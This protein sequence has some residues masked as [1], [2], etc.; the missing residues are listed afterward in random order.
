MRKFRWFFFVAMILVLAACANNNEEEAS[1]HGSVNDGEVANGYGAIDHGVDDKQTVDDA[2]EVEIGFGL[3]GD[4]IEEAS[5]VP[6]EEKE[7]ILEVFNVY[8]DAFNKKEIDRYMDTLSDQTESFDKAEERAYMEDVFAQFDPSREASD[9]T[10]VKYSDAEAQVFAQLKTSMKQLSSGLE[11]NQS[12][13]QVTVLKKED[14][15][16]KV[17]SIH[18]IGDTQNTD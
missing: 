8:I 16:W 15:E 18:Y 10:I 3:T 7:R 13:R 14:G 9:V 6:P 11:T 5:G 12:G 17:T 2:D 4:T 1:N